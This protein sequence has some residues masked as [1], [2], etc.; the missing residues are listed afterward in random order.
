MSGLAGTCCISE[1]NPAARLLFDETELP[2]FE[3]LSEALSLIRKLLDNPALLRY[4]TSNL[5]AK[6]YSSYEDSKVMDQLFPLLVKKQSS[7]KLSSN[8][9]GWYRRKVFTANVN[10]FARHSLSRL[11]KYCKKL[12]KPFFR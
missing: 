9:P 2:V 7:L 11:P 3:T 1:Y 4:Y 10:F 8:Y 12:L 6:V 5:S